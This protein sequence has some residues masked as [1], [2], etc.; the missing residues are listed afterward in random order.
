[1]KTSP[2]YSRFTRHFHA[3]GLVGAMDVPNSHWLVDEKRGVSKETP[4]LQQ[5]SMMID[6]MIT[7]SRPL[8]SIFTKR[9]S[10]WLVP[11]FSAK[12]RR[13]QEKGFVGMNFAKTDQLFVH[14]CALVPHG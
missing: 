10:N 5:V 3:Q 14:V 11:Q 9:T 2:F 1:V 8:Y 6:G 4:L 12:K 7:S 13:V